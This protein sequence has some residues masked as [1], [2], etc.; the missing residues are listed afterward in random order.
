MQKGTHIWL[1][2]QIT[3]N[4]LIF[5]LIWDQLQRGFSLSEIQ[6]ADF[7]TK[8]FPTLETLSKQLST[9]VYGH[10]PFP[11]PPRHWDKLFKW[12]S[13]DRTRGFKLK[14]DRFRLDIKKKYFMMQML[15]MLHCW[16]R[17]RLHSGVAAVISSLLSCVRWLVTCCNLGILPSGLCCNEYM[18]KMPA[19]RGASHPCFAEEAAGVLLKLQGCFCYR[20]LE[21][22]R[23][24]C[25]YG[26][27]DEQWHFG[28]LPEDVGNCLSLVVHSWYCNAFVSVTRLKI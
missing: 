10:H 28:C 4:P 5:T 15:L 21:D 13:C 25:Y 7:Q 9:V 6:L 27:G 11:L 18:G 14:E 22:K 1:Q 16:K 24:P 20:A 19:P 26:S 2:I 17:S 8:T 23:L 12:V 3:Q